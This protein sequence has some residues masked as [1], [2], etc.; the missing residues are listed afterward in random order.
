M[1]WGCFPS[2]PPPGEE[3]LS[4]LIATLRGALGESYTFDRELH[5]GGM[6][7]VFV[8]HDR[9]LG[10]MVAI[11]V[12]SPEV[13]AELKTERFRLEIQ[14][15]A[16][17]QHPHIVPLLFAGDA[18][19]LLY[20]TMPFI[21]GESLRTRIARDGAL[22]LN[23]AIRTLRQLASALAYAHKQGVVHRDI[24]PDN[25]LLAGEFALVTDFGVA[26]ALTESATSDGGQQLT[27]GGMAI[28]TPAYMAPEQALADPTI[29]HRADI[30]AFGIVAY[31]LL[32]GSPPFKAKTAQA[33]L[34]AH[35]TQPPEPVREKREEIPPAL[36]SLVMQCLEKQPEDRPQSANELLQLFDSLATGNISGATARTS[37]VPAQR[38]TP[39]QRG[40]IAGAA[41]VVLIAAGW[42]ALSAR[43]PSASAS[44]ANLT[45][46]AVLPL[47]NV[48]G[49]QDDEYF[50]DGLTDELASALARLPGLRVAS[51]TSSYSFKGSQ[52]DLSEIG[53]KL[54]VQAVIEGSVRRSGNRLRVNAQLVSVADG[55]TLWSESYDRDPQDV[56]DVQDE[57]A[58][59]IATA[60]RP[61]LGRRVETLS[62]ES[63]GTSSLDAWHT[64][65]RGRHHLNARGAE[66]LRLAVSYFDSAIAVDPA[67]AR[68]YA[69]RASA[70]ALLPEYTDAPPPN[71]SA[72]AIASANRALELD[73]NIADAHLAMGLA[74]VHEWKFAEAE[75]AYRKA[76]DADPRH[77]TAH[78]WYGELLYHTGRTDSSIAHIR[79]SGE[80]DPL[81]PVHPA[82]LG[83]SLYANGQYDAA[84]GELRKGIELAPTLGILHAMLGNI[85][86]VTGKYREAVKSLEEAARLEPEL[87]VRQ[88]YLAHALAKSGNE[89]RARAILARLGVAQPGRRVPRVAMAIA[90]L[91]LGEE[92]NA[93]SALEQAIAE[94]D[95]SLVT[96]ASLIPDPIFDPL[97]GNPRFTAL[98]ER[99]NLAA[100]ARR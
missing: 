99:M 1:L 53:K 58:R 70:Y 39:R 11:K 65:Q 18:A 48:G 82:A 13:A 71:S 35:I 83:Y 30:Y 26:K 50:S 75:A 86:L 76:L 38:S 24:K 88:G 72:L 92:E 69:G 28:G 16:K 66:N 62:S 34:A 43:T 54:N 3:Y 68:A 8:A 10:R 87:A 2:R 73:P 97:R 12:L 42:Y 27:S 47:E 14:L 96:T 80:L 81:A 89:A 78:Q 61:R 40:M 60:V 64:Y 45:S 20:F 67:F 29:D 41:T 57:I 77:A 74:G 46:V 4:D 52:A 94:H 36:A 95:I 85:H 84:L 63:R 33:T 15:A 90:Y 22:P 21:D 25:V 17:L 49:N 79:R 56:F 100:Y 32:T 55:F 31:E 51:R 9:S 7:R 37:A 6:S 19:G 5:G 91:G 93:L 59:A 23:D 44:M 98:L